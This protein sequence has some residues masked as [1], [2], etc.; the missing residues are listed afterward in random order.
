MKNFFITLI[1]STVI[2]Y[3][4]C[5]YTKCSLYKIEGSIKEVYDY[6][7]GANPGEEALAEMAKPKPWA[8]K[9]IFIKTGGQNLLKNKIIKE[10]VSDSHGNFSLS[11]PPG[12][13]CIVEASKTQ[14]LKFPSDP[15]QSVDTACMKNQLSACDYSFTIKNKNISNIL[16]TYHHHCAWTTPCVSYHGPLPPAAAPEHGIKINEK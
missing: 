4:S 10:I 9:K 16:I 12:I 11:L 7:G 13:Y 3:L 5:G 14:S 8:N 6:C 1:L 2:I 15:Y